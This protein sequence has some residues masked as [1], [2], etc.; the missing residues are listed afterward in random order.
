MAYQQIVSALHSIKN[1][2]KI[3]SFNVS[4]YFY[5]VL[6]VIYHSVFSYN[7]IYQLPRTYIMSYT[8]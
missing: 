5:N 2:F 6:L 1:V 3:K 4:N 7:V 8:N